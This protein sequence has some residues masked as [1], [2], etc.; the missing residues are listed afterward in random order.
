M[1]MASVLL[2]MK[3]PGNIRVMTDVLEAIGHTVL[4][5]P[6]PESLATALAQ[7]EE[8]CIAV[9]DASDFG[10]VDWSI[11][12][13]LHHHGVRFVMLYTAHGY[14]R[15]EQ[16]VSYGAAGFL[17]KPIKKSLFL[18]MLSGLL[19]EVPAQALTQGA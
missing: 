13:T 9:V 16:M 11:C 12:Q 3:R 17:P 8:R 1:T 10:A 18:K 15:G 4:S 14:G 6:T 7:A 2:V 19:G 5:A